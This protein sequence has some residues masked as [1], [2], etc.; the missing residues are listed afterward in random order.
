MHMYVHL[1]VSIMYLFGILGHARLDKLELKED[2]FVSQ[3]TCVHILLIG[4][5]VHNVL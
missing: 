2:L 5:N 3:L 4:G 1:Y